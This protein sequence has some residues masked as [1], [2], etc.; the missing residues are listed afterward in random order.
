MSVYNFIYLIFDK[1][2]PVYTGEKTESST[3][4]SEKL[5]DC[6][7]NEIRPR[8]ITLNEN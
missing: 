1:Q 6:I 8:S 5:D 4:G 3:N 2:A 7:K